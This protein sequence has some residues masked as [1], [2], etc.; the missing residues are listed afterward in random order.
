M[1]KQAPHPTDTIDE[2]ELQTSLANRLRGWKVSRGALERTFVFPNFKI[3]LEFVNRVGAKAEALQHHPDV[4]IRYDHV[5]L[6]LHSHD[7]G[8]ITRRDLTLAGSIEE[9]APEY[10]D[11]KT[12]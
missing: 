5:T 4:E 12:A 8:A 6:R 10:L 1:P 2:L 7:A 11:K 3:A 9:F